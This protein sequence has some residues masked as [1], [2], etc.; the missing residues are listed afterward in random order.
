[1]FAVEKDRLLY[2]PQF[3]A[4]GGLKW[5]D[6]SGDRIGDA[7]GLF[8]PVLSPDN[9][10]AAAVRTGGEIWVIDL[11]RGSST[12]VTSDGGAGEAVALEPGPNVAAVHVRFPGTLGSL[13]PAAQR[14]AKPVPIL[15]DTFDK[16]AARLAPDG[17]WL[18]YCSNET[19]RMEVYV[20]P[21][22][23]TLPGGQAL[24]GRWQISPRGGSHPIWRSDGKSLFFQDA[25]DI[26]E[27]PVQTSPQGV[28]AGTPVKRSE[29]AL[30]S[31]PPYSYDVSKDGKRF[32][33][34][35][36]ADEMR[37]PLMLM[38]NWQSRLR[39]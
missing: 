21:V 37:E 13:R 23:A 20:V 33:L 22:P 7:I 10:R 27:V 3:R 12:R 19:G 35:E 29:S 26:M 14:R 5:N 18:A 34:L 39:K 15:I 9:H 11:E 6:L 30:V 32:L 8:S 28:T 4:T 1:M 38:L 31:G 17:R 25:S 16:Y 36:G 2:R 24:T